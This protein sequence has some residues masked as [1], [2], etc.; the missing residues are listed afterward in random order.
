MPVRFVASVMEIF[1]CFQSR[2]ISEKFFGNGCG[3]GPNFTPFRLA[4]AIP[5]ACRLRIFSRSF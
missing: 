3:F 2:K 1:P 4:T 5:S